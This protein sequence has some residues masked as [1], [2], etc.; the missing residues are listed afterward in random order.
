M[1]EDETLRK[2]V[3]LGDILQA[4][5]ESLPIAVLQYLN[6]NETGLNESDDIIKRTFVLSCYYSSILSVII[7][8]LKLLSILFDDEITLYFGLLNYLR[9]KSLKDIE[10]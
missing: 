4:I 5:F 7:N 8:S 1:A 2:I 3:W 10:D 6:N 9:F